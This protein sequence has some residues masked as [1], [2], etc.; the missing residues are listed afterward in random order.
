MNK[1]RFS[2]SDCA[3]AIAQSF[4]IQLAWYDKPTNSELVDAETETSTGYLKVLA[5]NSFFKQGIKSHEM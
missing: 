1:K 5:D 3:H 4:D 2:K